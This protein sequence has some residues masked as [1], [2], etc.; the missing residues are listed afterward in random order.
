M[1][2]AELKI[3]CLISLIEYRR[4]DSLSLCMVLRLRCYLRIAFDFALLFTEKFSP[5]CH[6]ILLNK[7][8]SG[9][10]NQYD[11]LL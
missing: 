11:R 5:Y 2:L 3:G 8:Q 9:I 1:S 4:V 7:I 6:S 10:F